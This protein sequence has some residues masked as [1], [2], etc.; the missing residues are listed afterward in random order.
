MTKYVVAIVLVAIIV[1][2]GGFYAGQT[3]APGKIVE[4]EKKPPRT[5]KIGMT[6]AK[7]GGYGPMYW[8][9]NELS[10]EWAKI[11]N[12]QGGL[13]VK[14]YKQRLPVEIVWYDDKSDPAT[15]IKFYEKLVTEDKVDILIGPNCSPPTFAATTVPEKYGVPM[16]T[17]QAASPS[18]FSRGLKWVVGCLADSSYPGWSYE[19]FQMLKAEGKAKTIAFISEDSL[20]AKDNYLNAVDLAK[21]IGMRVVYEEV[22]PVETKDFTAVIT[23]MKALDPDIVYIASFPVFGSTFYKQAKEL[24]LSPREFH[25][26]WS[27][28]GFF[29]VVG[30]KDA[31]YVTGEHYWV[32]DWKVGN[33]KML[34]RICDNIGINAIEYAFGVIQFYGLEIAAAAIE[35]SE[36]LDDKQ[37]LLDAIWGLH[38][39]TTGSPDGVWYARQGK[40]VDGKYSGIGTINPFCVQIMKGTFN[41]V[42]P[43]S[44]AT[45]EHV[46]PMKP[47]AE[48]G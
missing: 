8:M 24:R 47:W 11:I 1:G 37:K 29:D 48:R 28:K 35:A 45:A 41:A 12:E 25:V 40:V 22:A 27:G 6:C 42:W 38:I 20:W 39:M 34:K 14:Q 44:V 4:V 13:Y 23:K 36:S 10:L 16:I 33:Y 32:P 18:I 21:G 43:K 30:W 5:I 3:L 31:E 15:T 17:Q 46:Y 7:T 2:A 19:Y 26:T 9:T